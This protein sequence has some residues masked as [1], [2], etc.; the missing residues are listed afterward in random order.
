M[1]PCKSCN[2]R[3]V[4]RIH[5]AWG[6]FVL[7]LVGMNTASAFTTSDRDACWSA[8]TNAFYYVTGDGRGHIRNREGGTSPMSFWQL[9]EEI[10][11][12]EDATNVN[13]QVAL[14]N[15]LCSGFTNQFNSYG[16]GWDGNSF[17]DDL[18]WSSTAFS[19]ACLLGIPPAV[20][21]QKIVSMWLTSVTWI[22]VTAAVNNIITSIAAQIRQGYGFVFTPPWSGVTNGDLIVGQFPSTTNLSS[23]LWVN[24]TNLVPSQSAL[25]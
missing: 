10:E 7:L 15:A 9:A 17:D 12:V 6:V 18:I 14:V 3:N 16:F 21:W 11:M 1:T 22:P 24:E 5:Y 2:L 8:W 25:I 13:N 23:W 20:R 4:S 19:R